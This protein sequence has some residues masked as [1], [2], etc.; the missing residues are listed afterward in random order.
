MTPRLVLK[1][2]SLIAGAVLL[3]LSLA[4]HAAPDK[5]DKQQGR[6]LYGKVLDQKD[7]PVAGAI[8][9][10]TN[11]RTHAVKTYIVSDE[12]TYRFPGL[13]TVDYEVYAQYNGRKSDTKSVSQFDDRSQVYIDLKIN[14][15]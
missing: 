11:T 14:T 2:A 15:Q 6:L 10:L 4:A 12:G 13:S 3:G 1:N 7:N 5:K 8:V 9:Y